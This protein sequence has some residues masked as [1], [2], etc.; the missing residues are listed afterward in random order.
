MV[1]A[2]AAAELSLLHDIVH[3]LYV[4]SWWNG[5]ERGWLSTNRHSAKD[6]GEEEEEQAMKDIDTPGCGY[7]YNTTSVLV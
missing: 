3:I 4:C 7:E 6:D 5:E 2:A 1:A